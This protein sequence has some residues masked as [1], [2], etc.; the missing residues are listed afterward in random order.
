M[1]Y[2][3]S[4]ATAHRIVVNTEN[5]LIKADKFHLPKN[6]PHCSGTDWD[7]AV[8]DGTEI[9]IQRPKKTKE[10]TKIANVN[11]TA[12]SYRSSCIIKLVRY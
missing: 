3:V 1:S 11:A 8:V 6:L 9:Q 12:S 7:V 4:Q 2:G 10:N 5:K